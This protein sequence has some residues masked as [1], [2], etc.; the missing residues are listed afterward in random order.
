MVVEP[1][2]D[3]DVIVP[4]VMAIVVAPVAVQLRVLLLPEFMLVGFAV[5]ELMAG[6]EPFPAGAGQPQPVNIIIIATAANRTMA[7][8]A[9]ARWCVCGSLSSK[10][11]SLSVLDE[12]IESMNALVAVRSEE[13]TSE[14]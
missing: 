1:L 13:H 2:A 14:L 8:T 9:G 7:I 3:V 10:E 12:V 5:K 6:T 4:G 11:G